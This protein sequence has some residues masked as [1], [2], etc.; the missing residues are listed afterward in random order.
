MIIKLDIYIYKYYD[1]VG[2]NFE[3]IV[4][5]KSSKQIVL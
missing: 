2:K 4:L 1:G 3:K 5:F